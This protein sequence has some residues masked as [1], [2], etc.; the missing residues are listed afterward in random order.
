MA[1]PLF[2]YKMIWDEINFRGLKG[3]NNFKEFIFQNNNEDI[4]NRELFGLIV[5]GRGQSNIEYPIPPVNRDSLIPSTFDNP[6][7]DPHESKILLANII[8]SREKL[9]SVS[10]TTFKYLKFE[11]IRNSDPR[12]KDHICY[13]VFAIKADGTPVTYSRIPSEIY[14]EY[15]VKFIKDEIVEE[16]LINN[17]KRVVVFINPSPPG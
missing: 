4:G 6:K 17:E 7:F 8:M 16:T 5:Y 3:D 11:S 9:A 13:Q 15:D 1:K 12:L 14:G 2:F 10:P